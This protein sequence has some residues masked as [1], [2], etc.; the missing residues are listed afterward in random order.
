MAVINMNI[1]PQ[2]YSSNSSK[3]I[4]KLLVLMDAYI[5][6]RINYNFKWDKTVLKRVAYWF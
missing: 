6:G 1:Y 4:N 3:P 2:P 5:Q